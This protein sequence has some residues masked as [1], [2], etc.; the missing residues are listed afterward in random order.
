MN[1]GVA[2]N[3]EHWNY[4]ITMIP[5][6][7]TTDHSCNQTTDK[8]INTASVRAEIRIGYLINEI[9]RLILIGVDSVC[10]T[11]LYV[12]FERRERLHD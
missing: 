12:S 7:L 5:E 8:R 1:E 11:Y 2:I 4:I 6:I 10:D 9:Y 3:L